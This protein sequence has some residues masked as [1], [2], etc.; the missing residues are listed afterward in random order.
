MKTVLDLLM[1]TLTGDLDLL[2]MPVVMGWRK[3]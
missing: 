2:T 1:T 3:I